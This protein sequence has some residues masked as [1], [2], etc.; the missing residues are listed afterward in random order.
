M[1]FVNS[2]KKLA[3]NNYY[4]TIYSQAKELKLKIFKND[5]DYTYLQARFL[6]FLSFYSGLYLDYALGDVDELI[7]KNEI[8]EDAYMEYKNKKNKEKLKEPERFDTTKN[9]TGKEIVNKS[10]WVFGSKKQVIK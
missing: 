8:Y 9:I 5:D 2:L 6:G 7:F 1:N 4:Q 10:K 3:K